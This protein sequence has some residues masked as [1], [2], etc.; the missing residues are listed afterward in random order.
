MLS[1]CSVI[2]IA[3]NQG[4]ETYFVVGFGPINLRP[5]GNVPAVTHTSSNQWG[6]FATQGPGTRVG[7][8][9]LEETWVSVDP[10]T[11]NAL[12]DTSIDALGRHRV[13][14]T[15]PAREEDKN[16]N[17]ATVVCLHGGLGA[18]RLRE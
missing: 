2:R 15:S 1:G 14:V 7:L 12:V 11:G 5:S 8:G 3:S 16:A 4:C 17:P 18:R 6:L 10:E 13:S 9:Y